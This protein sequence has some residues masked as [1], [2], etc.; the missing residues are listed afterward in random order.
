[1]ATI[2]FED[3]FYL[4]NPSAPPPTGT[5]LSVRRF[6]IV[7]KTADGA[8]VKQSGDTIDGQ[9]VFSAYPNSTLVVS[10]NGA[11][12]TIKGTVFHLADGR[13]LF[14]PTDGTVLQGATFVS[15]KQGPAQGPTPNAAFGPPCFAAGTLIT[16]A[17]RE[18]A[19]ETLQIGDM[20]QTLDHGA[21]PIRWIGRRTVAALGEF[22]PVAFESGAL[23]NRRRLL[24]SPEHRMLVTGWQAELH[25]GEPRVLVAARHLTGLPGIR[26]APQAQIEYLHLLFDRHEI[27]LAEGAASESFH[28]GGIQAETDAALR[29]E[30]MAI[31]PEFA[32]LAAASLGAAARILTGREAGILHP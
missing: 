16:L 6:T 7:D 11:T 12:T 15:I 26:R 28:P 5:A 13:T 14:S 21:R 1:M 2:T 29:A 3:Q 20:V 22:A 8:I 23:G 17:D 18:A 4:V 27:V 32:T 31:F 30:I 10:V 19:I 24:V 25:F 9:R